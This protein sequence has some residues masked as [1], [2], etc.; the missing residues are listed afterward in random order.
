MRKSKIYG[1][2]VQ[3]VEVQNWARGVGCVG[4]SFPLTYLGLPVG[5][6]MSRKIAWRPIVEKV[7]SRLASWKARIMS[8][9]GRLTL[10]KSVLGSLP[11]YFLSLFRAPSG[12]IGEIERIRRNFFWGGGMGVGEI[13]SKKVHAW[14]N[15]ESC[16]KSFSKGGINIGCLKDM[17]L[18]LLAKWWWRFRV[19]GDSLWSRV[20]RSIYGEEARWEMGAR[21][22][23]GRIV[24]WAIDSLSLI[25]LGLVG[26]S[27]I[28]GYPFW[29]GVWV[30]GNW[31]WKWHWN[32]EPRGR[33]LG[34]LESLERRLLGWSPDRVKK[35]VWGWELD[36]VNGFSVNKLRDLMA[37][38]V[39]VFLWK[40]RLGRIPT[41]V[42][43]DRLGIDLHS[44]L[45]PRCGE[46]VEDIDH[47]FLKCR[48]INRFWIRVGKWWNKSVTG[49]DSVAHFLQEDA[50]LI[51][52]HNG[53]DWWVGVKWV[54]LYLL[55]D[56]R[57]RLVF[58]NK[59]K[60]LDV[61]FSE[62]QRTAFE[63]INNK[64]KK[65]AIDIVGLASSFFFSGLVVDWC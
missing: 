22:T 30:E 46:A 20:I 4:G 62:W 2:G 49:F 8:F 58:E 1:L 17:N 23:F 31:E 19:D 57:N 35:D 56:Q 29:I 45:C 55:W 38:Q 13:S 63:W 15:W 42:V 25:I 64:L 24:G 28:R 36:V 12:V 48:E 65:D 59:K 43:L 9:G 33:A 54:F 34:E 61:C 16:V 39:N 26:W 41:R 3:D 11:L 37:D 60:G 44:V 21:H 14:V 51:R 18:A 47:V 50:D 53:K 10:V 40:L 5:A 32:R 7:R 52:N 6:S 27:R